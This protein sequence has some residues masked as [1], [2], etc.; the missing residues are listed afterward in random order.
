M[1][2]R[3]SISRSRVAAVALV[4]VIAGVHF[5]QYVDFMSEVPTVGVLF[6]LNA[7][8]G[9][10]LV[11]ALISPERNLRL[12]AAIGGIGLAGG[13][14]VSIM[15]ALTNNFFGYSEPTLRLPIV[16]AIVSELAVI[17]LLVQLARADTKPAV[18][19]AVPSPQ[20]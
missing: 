8:G 18:P 12:F 9:T 17:P 5:E 7:A 13:S 16:I 2:S 4:A 10:G 1:L 3:S 11:F 14:L 15:I 20:S 19:A 6:L